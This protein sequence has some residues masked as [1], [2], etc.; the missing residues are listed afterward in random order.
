MNPKTG[1]Y[2]KAAEIIR[3]L[4][5]ER[6][7][8]EQMIAAARKMGVKDTELQNAGVLPTGKTTREE[9][10]A[11]FDSKVPKVRVD[12]Y[13]ENP[14]YLSRDESQRRIALQNRVYKNDPLS[15]EEKGDLKRL[16]YRSTSSPS[17]IEDAEYEAPAAT[18]FENYQTRGGDNY[19]ERL[20]KYER[21]PHPALAVDRQIKSLMRQ[22]DYESPIYGNDPSHPKMQ[23]H[24]QKLSDLQNQ[25]DKIVEQHGPP[26][27]SGRRYQSSHWDEHPDVLA[28][29]RLKDRVV[30]PASSWESAKE[31]VVPV[32][33]KIAEHMGAASAELGSG[34]ASYAV[35]NGLISPEE[36]AT[37]SKIKGWRNEYSDKPGLEKRLLHVEEVQSDWAQEGRDKGFNT[38][39]KTQEY[40]DYIQGLKQRYRQKLSW[41]GDDAAID[42]RMDDTL[43]SEMAISLG[44]NEKRL[45]LSRAQ[46]NEMTAPPTG[47]YVQNTQHWTDLALKNVLR[48][49][50]LGNYDGIVFTPGQAQ[51]DRYGLEKQVDSISY[52]PA[53]RKLTAFKD[54]KPIIAKPDVSPEDVRG[55]IGKDLSERLLHPDNATDLGG[56]DMFHS[57][58]GDDLKM[59][60][61][62]MKGYYDNILPKSVMRLAQQHDPS[63]KPGEPVDIGEGYQGF[64]LPMTDQLKQSITD[65]GFPAF[66]RGG[67]VGY[68]QGGTPDDQNA[69]AYLAAPAAQGAIPDAGRVRGGS[70]LLQTQDEAPLEGLPASARIPLTGQVI[71]AGPDPRIRAVARSYMA[72][73]GMP[74]NPPTKYAKVDPARA[75]RIAAAYDEMEDNPEHPLTRASYAEMIKETLAQYEAAKAAGFKAE[76][77]HPRKQKD[78]YEASPRLAVEDVRNNNHMWVYP[79]YAGYGS[80]DPISEED[81]RR[82]PMLQLTGENWNGIPVTVNDIFRAVH[83]YFGHAK[84]GVGFR[85]DGE[86]NA[87]R[88]HASMYSPLARMAMT[89]ETRG[90]N[91]WLN[92]GPHGEKNRTART[93]DTEFAPQKVGI[94]PH[95]VHHEGAEDFMLPND[96]SGMLDARA[97]HSVDIDKAL[98][99]TRRFTGGW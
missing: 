70:G 41:M 66:K 31:W 59:G 82:N 52:H 48:E 78:P 14:S 5:Q 36:A 80:G 72:S 4:P 55:L 64:H 34:A 45:E 74:Y 28:H 73:A 27:G 26:A 99:L 76:F 17:V 85:H 24:Y 83:D 96:I 89:S 69:G 75:K 91:S 16:T 51:A 63:V 19:R 67:R 94:L 71:Q 77:W 60:G 65:K 93:E 39:Q 47:P 3:S 21:P 13:G 9:L 23:E 88:S 50:A 35:K 22:I 57:L 54:N 56:G 53:S 7:T 11:F 84:E 81:A 32:V 10:A 40:R 15:D 8:A 33:Q 44:E 37:L 79:T 46:N 30:G 25:M 90:Q 42:K 58:T 68:A 49:A 97:K 29:I 2:S 61:E 86:E 95:W 12:Q 98:S 43:L 20:L 6:G 18:R 62:G 1:L 38:G 87:W 92:F